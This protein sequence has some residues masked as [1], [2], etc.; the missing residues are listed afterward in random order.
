MLVR[1]QP[2]SYLIV[3]G[4][5]EEGGAPSAVLTVTP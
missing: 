3:G 5:P 4:A 1:V 2:G